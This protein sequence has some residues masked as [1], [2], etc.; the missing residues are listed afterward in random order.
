MPAYLCSSNHISEHSIVEFDDY[1]R[2]SDPIYIHF[3]NSLHVSM[4][5]EIAI[6]FNPLAL[7]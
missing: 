1:N 5:G 4:L 3:S 7:Q 2:S 6:Q